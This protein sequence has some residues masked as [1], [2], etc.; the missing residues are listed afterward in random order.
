MNKNFTVVRI[1]DEY[2][3]IINGGFENDIKEG[4][5]FQIYS[6]GVSIYDPE[7]PSKLLGK[8]NNI[9][10]TVVAEQVQEN[11]TICKSRTTFKNIPTVSA[12]IE[13]MGTITTQSTLSV[14]PSQIN[15]IDFGDKMIRVGDFVKKIS[16]TRNT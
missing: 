16:N 2:S 9:K 5:Y 8:F 13:G 7:D 4:D 1:L 3:L 6:E 14:D 12:I 15:P 10:A 11:L